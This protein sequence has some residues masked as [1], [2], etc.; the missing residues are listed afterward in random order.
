MNKLKQKSK[1]LVLPFLTVVLFGL[2]FIWVYGMPFASNAQNT[3]TISFG[4]VGDS[5]GSSN[6]Q[7]VFS[8]VKNANLNFFLHVGDFSYDEQGGPEGWPGW[9]R[10]IV[11]EDFP[12]EIVSGNHDD[13]C[14]N[15]YTAGL[16]NKMGNLQ[17]SYGKNYY[18]DYPASSPFAR[19]IMISPALFDPDEQWL[20]SAIDG[21]RTGNIPW[22]IV[23]MHVNCITTGQKSC[24]LGSSLMDLL[25]EK[26]VDVILQGHDHNYQRSKQLSCAVTNTTQQSCIVGQGPNYTK[27]GGSVIVING[28]GGNGFYGVDQGDP[29]AGYFAALNSDTY[30]F[31]KF[32]LTNTQLSAQ[33]VRA[34]GGN[35]SDSFTI[36]GTANPVPT[37]TEPT[38]I[39]PT[40]QC[41]G[42]VPCV[43]SATPTT[44]IGPTGGVSTM[45]LTGTAPTTNPTLNPCVVDGEASIQHKKKHKKHKKHRHNKKGFLSKFIEWILKFIEE[46]MRRLGI[47]NPS[48]EEPSPDLTPTPDPGGNPCPSPTENP[49]ITESPTENPTVEPTTTSSVGT[50]MDVQ[51]TFYG[52]YDNDPKGSTSISNPVLH[53]QA[54]GTGTF[55]DPLTFASPQGAGEYPVGAKIYVPSVQKYFIREDIC[56]TSWT[57]PNGCGAVTHV[58][59]YVGNPSDAQSVVACE[60]A[61]TPSGTGKIILNPPANLPYDPTPIWNQSTGKCMT[62][63]S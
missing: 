1:Q 7:A 30:G 58:D 39:V 22:V 12:F 35:F 63:H 37:G 46:L 53:Q 45:P 62:P 34:A 16:P 29:E 61:L 31:T 59:L 32:T 33:F 55:Q 2:S 52:A 26:K 9:V 50:N 18:F 19:F 14:I 40:Y 10:S 36:A 47:A 24:E 21:A 54:G 4:S 13:C 3:A 17:G 44:P 49:G 38:A 15:S 25:L 5:G 51:I 23:G 8:G 27:G 6:A 57:A 48:P 41:L 11:G 56:A 28:A 60:D 42:G 20:I 43:P